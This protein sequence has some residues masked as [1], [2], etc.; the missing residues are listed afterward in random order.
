MRSQAITIIVTS[1]F[2]VSCLYACER[3]QKKGKDGPSDTPE[4][5]VDVTP[6]EAQ[7]GAQNILKIL[8]EQQAGGLLIKFA[9]IPE[10][11]KLECDMDGQ[12]I[13][14]CHDQA[15]LARPKAGDHK[16]S[17]IASRDGRVIALGESAPFTV[18][19]DGSDAVDAL[20]P[21]FVAMAGDEF[22]PGMTLDATK[23]YTFKFAVNA[24]KAGCQPDLYC[25]YGGVHN[26]LWAICDAKAA[27]SFKIEAGLMAMGRQE[28]AVQGRCSDRVGPTSTFYWYGVPADYQHLA[29]RAVGD[30]NK[31]YILYLAKQD[32]CPTANV[33]FECAAPGSDDDF[34]LCPSGSTIENPEQ[35]A[36]VRASCDGK[37]GPVL[38][39]KTEAN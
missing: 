4:K 34:A 26:D 3:L 29:V 15:L 21:L 12:A 16:I 32:D 33:R 2:S 22:T 31:R 6:L 23:E 24:A 35:G 11:A 9:G 10:G 19:P 17:A 20:D 13:V 25:R 36:R 27:L 30:S 14:P 8:V 18:I 28:L 37:K 7:K 5:P 38:T 1:M 39:L